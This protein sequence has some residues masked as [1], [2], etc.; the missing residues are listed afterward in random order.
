MYR[1]RVKMTKLNSL[2]EVLKIAC[3]QAKRELGRELTQHEIKY[4]KKRAYRARKKLMKGYTPIHS[5]P[6][7]LIDIL[8]DQF[9]RLCDSMLEY[10]VSG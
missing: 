5:I 7:G 3:D 1:Q 10:H 8:T 4:L 9:N 2:D 6:K